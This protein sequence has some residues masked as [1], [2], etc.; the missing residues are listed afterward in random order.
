MASA[1]EMR[2]QGHHTEAQNVCLSAVVGEHMVAQFAGTF[3]GFRFLKLK[4]I[5]LQVTE[6]R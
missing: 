6:I 4:I 1:V 5:N 3:H 2:E